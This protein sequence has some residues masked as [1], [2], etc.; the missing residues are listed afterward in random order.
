M[1]RLPSHRVRVLPWLRRPGGLLLRNWLAITIGRE[2]LAWRDLDAGEL[3][4]ELAHVRQWRRHGVLFALR[5]LA[6]SFASWRAGTGWYHGNRFEI[7][8]RR[9]EAKA[10]RAATPKAETRQP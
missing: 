10:R 1:S 7:E 2:I 4:H 5:Y 6:A 3:A 9:A 8:A